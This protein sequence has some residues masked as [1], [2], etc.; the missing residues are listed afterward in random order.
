MVS[1]SYGMVEFNGIETLN[2]KY[3]TH[4]KVPLIASSGDAGFQDPEFPASSPRVWSIGATDLN[5][6]A[7]KKA[8]T[9][10]AAS[11]SGSNCSAWFAKP[12]WQK[13]KNCAGRTSADISAAGDGAGGAGFLVYD[14]YLPKSSRAGSGPAAPAS[15]RHSSRA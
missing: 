9:E 8:Y 10:K 13:D 3:Y 4:P 14:S 1:N 11:F 7:K 6:S 5:Y 12:S 2:K 15:R